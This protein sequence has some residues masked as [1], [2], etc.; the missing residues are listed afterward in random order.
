MEENFADK[1]ISEATQTLEAIIDETAFDAAEDEKYAIG[2]IR[3][4]L[5]TK[6]TLRELQSHIKQLEEIHAKNNS[7]RNN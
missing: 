7:T 1:L 3:K 4:A 2:I 6:R 5:D